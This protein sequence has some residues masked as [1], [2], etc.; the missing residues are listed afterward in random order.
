MSVKSKPRLLKGWV[1]V[2]GGDSASAK[3][4]ASSVVYEGSSNIVE[5]LANMYAVR[6]QIGGSFGTLNI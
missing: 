2:G 1:Q 6:T 5:G 4:W 3:Q